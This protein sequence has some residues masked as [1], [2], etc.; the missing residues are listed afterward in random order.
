VRRV[1]LSS[2][3]HLLVLLA[4][5]A[6][7]AYDPVG[8]GTTRLV[9]DKGFVSVLRQNGV[10]LSAAAPARLAGSAVSFPMSGGKF[11]PTSSNGV[12]E[13]E[14]ALVL[15]AGKRSIP[16]KAL[17]LKTTQKRSPLS[18]KVGGSQLKLATAGSLAVTRAGFGEKVE[19]GSL[20]L[21]AKLATRLGKKLRLRHVFAEGQPLGR[22]SSKANPETVRLLPRN[23][24]TLTLDPGFQAKLASLFVAV[25]PIFPVEH[26]VDFTLPIAGGEI[27][28]N[29]SLGMVETAGSLELIQQGGGQAFWAEAGMDLAARSLGAEAELRPSPPYAGKLGRVAIATLG[30][31]AVSSNPGART[32]TVAGGSLALDGASAGNFNELFAKPQGR[33][34][35]F[36]AGEAV[37]SIS[38]T[39]QGQ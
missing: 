26:P 9:L 28:P 10:K 15:S 32:V 31:T 22:T 30:P 27:A 6:K 34:N 17:Q 14:G 37:G 13:H 36:V 3:L 16:I 8:S 20:T 38:F 35:V 21:S 18:A 12:V 4:P 1:C 39:A 7:A 5:T 29:G 23:K 24:V 33:D 2:L 25:N 11:D 19:V